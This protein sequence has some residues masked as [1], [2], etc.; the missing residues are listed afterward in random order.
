LGG[1]KRAHQNVERRKDR[2]AQ[3][4]VRTPPQFAVLGK[5]GLSSGRGA[6]AERIKGEQGKRKSGKVTVLN[7]RL[8]L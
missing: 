1:G 4:R 7:S 5:G 8:G 6:E 3:K 2:A